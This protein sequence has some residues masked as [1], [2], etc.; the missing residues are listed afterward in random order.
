MEENIEAVV[1]DKVFEELRHSTTA[2]KYLEIIEHLILDCQKDDVVKIIR[3]MLLDHD[4]CC[5]I[6]SNGK[7]IE[8]FYDRIIGIINSMEINKSS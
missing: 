8:H 6:V 2:K 7:N 4:I 3:N 5:Q 1:S